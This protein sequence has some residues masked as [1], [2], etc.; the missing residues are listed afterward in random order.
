[1]RVVV[2]ALVGVSAAACEA[3]A[4][5][6]APRNPPTASA[7]AAESLDQRLNAGDRP[8][9]V[10]SSRNPFRFAVREAARPRAERPLPP[11]EGLPELPLPIATPPLRLLGIATRS[12]GSRVAVMLVGGDLVLA[13]QGERLASRYTVSSIGDES[14]ELTDALGERP[15]R[16]D[17]P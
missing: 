13:R 11:A 12:D 3:G 5:R 8:A 7:P 16:L 4:D 10:A 14:V 2:A 15:M 1:V 17:L 9:P 6:P